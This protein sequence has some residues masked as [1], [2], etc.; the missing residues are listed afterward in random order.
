MRHAVS[1]RGLHRCLTGP[2]RAE[3]PALPGRSPV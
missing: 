2:G 1:I 3:R